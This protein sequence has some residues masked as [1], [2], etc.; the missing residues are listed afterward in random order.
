MLIGAIQK[1]TLVDYPGVVAATIFTQGC[2]FRCGFCHN[3]ELLDA[4]NWGKSIPEKEILSFL[5][6]RKNKLKGI[7]ITGGEPTIQ[8]DLV[9]FIKKV[10][11]M[12]YLVKLDTN[13][14]NPHVLRE[15]LK[16]KL[17]DF[18]AMDIKGPL[19]KYKEI[20]NSNIDVNVIK[21]SI[22]LIKNSTIPHEFRTTV[23]KSQL[24]TKDILEIGELLKGSK[25]YVLQRFIPS[26]TQDLS[27]MKESTYTKEEFDEMRDS[28]KKMIAEVKIR[29]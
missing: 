27:F 1:T 23:V 8:K 21:E 24:N 13:G 11:D 10:K 29:F 26:K 28:L 4:K 17:I 12:G 9:S 2:N 5:K 7:C 25:C 6:E 20:S 19:N 22:E 16:K 14:S 15:L 3:P 18:V